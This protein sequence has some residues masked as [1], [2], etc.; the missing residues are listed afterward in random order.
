MIKLSGYDKIQKVDSRSYYT[1]YSARDIQTS[2][3]VHLKHFYPET[4]LSFDLNSF[5]EELRHLKKIKSEHVVEFIDLIPP[6]NKSQ[7]GPILIYESVSGKSLSQ[8][9]KER[10]IDIISFLEMA[11][12][13]SSAIAAL[14]KAGFFANEIIP[15]HIIVNPKKNGIKITHL[16]L[17]SLKLLYEQDFQS[18]MMVYDVLPYIS[19]EQTGRVR[20]QADYRS[21]FYVIG[22]ILYAMLIGKPPFMDK[23]PMEIIHGHIAQKPI[24]PTITRN[25]IPEA[26]SDLIM[27]LLAKNPDDRYQSIYSLQIDLQNYLVEYSQT[28][29]ITSPSSDKHDDHETFHPPEKF[30]GGKMTAYRIFPN[31]L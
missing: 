11:I 16:G 30:Y 18:S 23:K 10:S 29:S 19:P 27:K 21:D 1:L 2:R 15:E 22:T 9:I 26:I 20:W 6:D 5:A 24:P 13:L 28:K 17:H 8:V 4:Y 25:D 12:Q 31:T 14:H 3:P 7:T